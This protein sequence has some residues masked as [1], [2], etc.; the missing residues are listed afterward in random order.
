MTVEQII[1]MCAARGCKN[2][3]ECVTFMLNNYKHFSLEDCRK[4]AIAYQDEYERKEKAKRE[5][6][7]KRA[8]GEEPPKKDEAAA[9][10]SS[11]QQD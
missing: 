4:I 8:S 10:D 2:L 5:E 3:K 9:K 6:I 11:L 7:E 1:K